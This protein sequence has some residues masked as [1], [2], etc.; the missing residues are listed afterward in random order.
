MAE[1]FSAEYITAPGVTMVLQQ[2][3]L[4]PAAAGKARADYWPEENLR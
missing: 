4:P 1:L 2:D 3:A